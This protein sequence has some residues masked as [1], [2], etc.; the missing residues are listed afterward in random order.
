[1][2]KDVS[3][4]AG[5]ESEFHRVVRVLV[6]AVFIPGDGVYHRLELGPGES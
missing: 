2:G 5:Q 6:Q 4:G 1:M 3:C